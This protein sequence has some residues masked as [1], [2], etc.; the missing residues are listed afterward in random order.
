MRVRSLW[1]LSYIGGLQRIAARSF[2]LPFALL[3]KANIVN[4]VCLPLLLPRRNPVST[5]ALGCTGQ[6]R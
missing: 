4:M 6:D 3:P 2:S 1:C 5:L